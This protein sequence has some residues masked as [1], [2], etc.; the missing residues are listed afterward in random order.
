MRVQQ[1]IVLFSLFKADNKGFD[2]RAAE[3]IEGVKRKT[4]TNS[5]NR[6]KDQL[7]EVKERN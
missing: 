6:E 2:E 5:T 4:Y 7:V 1:F 3:V